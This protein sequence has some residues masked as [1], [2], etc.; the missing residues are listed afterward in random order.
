MAKSTA[1]ASSGRTTLVRSVFN[2]KRKVE[3][4]T[5]SPDGWF[6]AAPDDTDVNRAIRTNNQERLI[7]LL[8]SASE[9]AMSAKLHLIQLATS[10]PYTRLPNM[11]SLHG[12]FCYLTDMASDLSAILI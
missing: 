12:T 2:R 10:R 4:G 7:S 1:R 6:S 5:L 9:P 11:G 3:F 8:G